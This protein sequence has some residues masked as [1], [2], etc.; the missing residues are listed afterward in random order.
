MRTRLLAV[1][2]LAVVLTALAVPA[3]AAGA[4]TLHLSF[5]GL[6]AQANFSS[7]DPS[8]CFLTHVFVFANDG[9]FRTGTGRL[10]K[11][12][13]ATVAVSQSDECTQTDLL[14][15]DGFAVLAPGQFQIDNKFTAA[16]L[17][18]TI[19]V[20]D[21]LSGASF[22]VNVNVSWT[23]AGETFSVKQRIHETFPGFK[24]FKRFDGTGRAAAAS[25]TVSDG[26]TNFTPEPALNADLGSIRQGEL[27]IIHV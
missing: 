21:F 16:T 13:T 26:T 17:T 22:R 8:G 19:E 14:L 9:H 10:E 25:G 1:I 11:A 15:A 5:D 23:G 20:F 3:R 4:E 18:A 6:T 12:A 24:V 2:S 27:D 7:R